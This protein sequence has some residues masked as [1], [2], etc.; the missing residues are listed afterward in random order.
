MVQAV[1]V[2]GWS[3]VYLTEIQAL[4]RL[5]IMQRMRDVAAGLNTAGFVSGFQGSPLNNMD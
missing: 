2:D 4:T 3:Q 1:L 5:L